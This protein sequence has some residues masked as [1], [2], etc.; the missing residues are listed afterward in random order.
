MVSGLSAKSEWHASIARDRTWRDHVVIGIDA[1]PLLGQGGISGYVGPLMRELLAMPQDAQYRLV[2]RRG[3][4]AHPAAGTLD[5]LGPV[6]RIRV[7]DRVLFFW[8]DCLGR[9]FPVYR[10]LWKSLDL[11]L[12][13]CLVAP[14]LPRGR[15]VSIVYDLIPLRLPEL[16]PDHEEFRKKLEQL[17]LR[18]Y[19]IVA[20]SRRTRD[21]LV[22]LMGVDPERV[23]VIYP[24]RDEAFHPIP[25]SQAADVAR[26]YGLSGPY[27][28]YV[29]ALG[30]HKN[31]TGLLRAYQLAREEGKISAKLL[32]VG[33]R[34][35]G[36]EALTLLRT[37]RVRD[38]IV[39]PGFVSEA[40]LPP[41]YA[42]AELFAFPS[43]YEGFGL[44]VL[45]AMACGTPV[46]VSRAGALPEV[47]GEAGLYVDPEDCAALADLIRR[48]LADPA[49][50]AKLSVAG[51]KQAENFC[52]T[53]SAVRLR[54]LLQEAAG[55]KI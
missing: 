32:I 54:A 49:L 9:P 6:T 17:L 5:A 34:H 22:E 30:S 47:A 48:V 33:S 45:E 31:V 42:G 28:L 39:A 29:G 19:A 18:S 50:K 26:R 3:W 2:L 38:D 55:H 37:L 14:V 21:D 15:V 16:F 52:W 8:W 7:P 10:R 24:G 25:P 35:W 23:H 43:R 4:M 12:A 44:P 11:F 20:I 13:T 41:L 1:G 27:I 51:L 53:R 36:D 46:I 40:D